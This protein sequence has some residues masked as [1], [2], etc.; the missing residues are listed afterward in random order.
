MLPPEILQRVTLYLAT[1][2]VAALKQASRVYAGLPLHDAFWRSRFDLGREFDFVFEARADPS[3]FRG[4][5][6]AFYFTVRDSRHQPSVINRKRTWQLAGYLKG[7][8]L[9]TTGRN[10]DGIRPN[11]LQPAPPGKVTRWVTE[12]RALTR[13]LQGKAL[14]VGAKLRRER[15]LPTPA[16][17]DA[18]CVSTIT[19]C[20]RRYISGIRV[21][22]IDGGSMSLG[23]RHTQSTR[24][25]ILVKAPPYA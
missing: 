10:C 17:A 6:E 2:D 5:W 9:R 19:F 14:P 21:R 12:S 4:R 1:P 16:D 22:Q 8:T 11:A 13:G 24:E 23:Y 25:E 20:G 18:L 7:L 3:V 15:I